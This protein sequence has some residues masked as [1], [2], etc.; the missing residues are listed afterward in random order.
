[1]PYSFRNQPIPSFCDLISSVETYIDRN[2]L[3][4]LKTALRQ[5][6]PRYQLQFDKLQFSFLSRPPT[7]IATN[8]GVPFT[9]QSHRKFVLAAARRY[10]LTQQARG[11]NLSI[12]SAKTK[13]EHVAIAQKCRHP[14]TLISEV[15]EAP[16]QYV[17]AQYQTSFRLFGVAPT[18]KRTLAHRDAMLTWVRNLAA[19]LQPLREQFAVYMPE[20][21][22]T[23]AGHVHVPLFYML[24]RCVGYP[25]P[26]L[27]FRFFIG[28]PLIG[29][30][31][32]PALPERERKVAPLSD[33]AIKEVAA[34]CAEQCS[35]M[36]GTLSREAGIKSMEKMEAE[37]KTLSL[38]GPFSSFD[39]LCD[40][41]QE[42]MRKLP[43]LDKFVLDRELVIASPQFS[44]E[45]QNRVL[46]SA[47]GVDIAIDFENDAVKKIKVRNIWNGKTENKLAGYK[48]TYIPNTHADVSA[49]ILHWISIFTSLAIAFDMHAWPSDFTGAYRQMPIQGMHLPAG[50]CCYWDYRTGQ[51]AYAF[52]RSLPFGSSLAPAGWSEVTFAL[53]FIMAIAFLAIL[54]HCVDDVMCAEVVELVDSSRH[55]FITICELIGLTLDMDKTLTP[56][57]KLLYLGL[58]I[59]LPA[60][61][62][63]SLDRVF[64]FQ[65]PPERR[66]N[67]IRHLD[68][69]LRDKKLTPGDASSHRGRLFFYT[70][71]AP[72]ARSFL[73]EFAARQYAGDLRDTSLTAELLSAIKYF[74]TLLDDPHFLEG[75]HPADILNRAMSIVYTDGA[76]E[77]KVDPVKGVGGVM[78]RDNNSPPRYF[79]E[80]ELKGP[81]F[82]TFTHIAPIEMHAIIRALFLFGPFLRHRAVLF[83]VDNTHA[84]GC[85]LKGGA[86]ISAPTKK[87]SADAVAIEHSYSHY[88]EFLSLDEGLRRT[89]NAQARV[90]WKLISRF[91]IL[92]WFEY[93]HTDCNI[94]DPPSRGL[95]LPGRFKNSAVRMTSDFWL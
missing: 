17:F 28:A 22:A 29:E 90:I 12:K 84:I 45:E 8:S 49:I 40:A 92:P 14:S 19:E 82:A 85:I 73:A 23:I 31:T 53:C 33:A 1:M 79:A 2:C 58:N 52:Y 41:I 11:V 7:A 30:F 64:A 66:I 16:W 75:V 56:C 86:T 25:N 54:T 57:S 89:M 59:V 48:N 62:P 38:E 9:I 78:F 91:N 69:I 46:N 24:L 95:P 55:V 10:A 74:R 4:P 77:G 37:F 65:L 47:S 21:A 83:F 70:F 94:A 32:S 20:P 68:A 67:L 80:P 72:E 15:L 93:V 39:K 3:Q 76:L 61:I 6:A 51:P 50:G 35:H 5:L 42:E 87:R 13:L 88:N 18:W 81:Q 60:R 44:V 36:R 27:A 34:N 63:R 43:G 26:D 71:W